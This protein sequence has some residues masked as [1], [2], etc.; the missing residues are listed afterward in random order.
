MAEQRN[1][2]QF[3]PLSREMEDVTR[4]DIE[5]VLGMI[6]PPPSTEFALEMIHELREGM[7]VRIEELLELV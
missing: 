7:S 1:V 4:L 6:T 2:A 5:R 3:E